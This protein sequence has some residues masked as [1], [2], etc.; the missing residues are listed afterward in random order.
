MTITKPLSEMS[1][2]DDWTRQ[3]T[4]T[5]IDQ[6]REKLQKLRRPATF[7]CDSEHRVSETCDA[8]PWSVIE[9]VLK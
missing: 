3:V 2:G 4:F 7:A 9:E 5:V 1:A 6:V 8:V